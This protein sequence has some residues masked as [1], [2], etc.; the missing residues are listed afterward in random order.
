MVCSL[1][2]AE[3]SF[4]VYY[5]EQLTIDQLI[6]LIPFF[7]S[8][9]IKLW[10]TINQTDQLDEEVFKLLFNLSLTCC[11]VNCKN[12]KMSSGTSLQTLTFVIDD[13]D[14]GWAFLMV[15]IKKVVH[16]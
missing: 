11:L 16:F 2:E 14:E 6:W 15:K 1:V 5:N 10:C 4:N 9:S 7:T 8:L 12:V 3:W 13:D